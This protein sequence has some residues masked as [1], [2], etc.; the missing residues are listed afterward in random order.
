MTTDELNHRLNPSE[1]T[2]PDQYDPEA[3]S[4]LNQ[5]IKQFKLS[6]RAYHRV[7][8]VARTIADLQLLPLLK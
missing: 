3:M 2:A 1:L 6:T 4:I 7:L 8:R 5:A